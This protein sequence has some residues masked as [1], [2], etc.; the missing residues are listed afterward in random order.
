MKKLYM[1]LGILM[2]FV[3]MFGFVVANAQ[4][5]ERSHNGN[6][7]HL[8]LYEKDSSNWNIVE[9]GA[10]GK[11]MYKDDK[12]VFNGHN[13]EVGVSYTLISYKEP[14]SWPAYDNVVLGEGT[15]DEFGNVNIKGDMLELV[16]NDYTGYT[17]GDYYDVT[18]SKVWL[19]LS[20]DMNEDTL[21]GWNPTEYLFENNLI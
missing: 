4:I 18:G 3:L 21:T 12:F 2:G 20:D 13:L 6:A 7:K 17:T 9:D 16:I 19:V 8:Y 15:V 14:T 1:T 11:M 5:Q 10:W